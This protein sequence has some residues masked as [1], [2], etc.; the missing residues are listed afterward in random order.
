MPH[1]ETDDLSIAYEDMGKPDGD[2]VLFLHG[3]PDDA[4]TWDNVAERLQSEP[5]RLIIPTLRGFGQTVFRNAETPRTA[6]S[7]ILALDAIALMDGLGI[8]RFSVVGHDWGSNI[9]EALAVGW[10]DR[11]QRMA[12]LAS[13]PRLGGAKTSP[14]WHAQ[15]QWY[16]WFMATERGA[17][18]VAKDPKGFAHIHW[19]NWSPDGWFDEATF[20]AVAKS[21]E[22]PDWVPVTLHSYRARWEEAE[23]DPRSQWLETRIED[24]KT[25]ALPVLYFQGREDGVNP[26]AV[27]QN[28]SEK[29]SGP[30]SRI[31]LQNVGHFPQREDP[32]TV[33]KELKLFLTR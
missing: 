4:S 31:L 14:F 33:S 22:N 16:H 21:F 7:G 11:V 18:A 6:N 32:E 26:P 30:F 9:A 8:D 24:T 10:P 29:F 3:W 23:P 27:S 25:L 13:P 5:H 19:T 2:P 17:E 20:N 28:V 15:L 12:L 1:L